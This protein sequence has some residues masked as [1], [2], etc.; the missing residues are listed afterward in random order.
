MSGKHLASSLMRQYLL[1]LYVAR[2]DQLETPLP[3]ARLHIHDGSQVEIA[4]KNVRAIQRF[5][6]RKTLSNI[7]Q[8]VWVK[9]NAVSGH[10]RVGKDGCSSRYG[11][12]RTRESDSSP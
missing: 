8:V 9:D 4:W 5:N 2:T 12:Q 3:I 11:L 6:E 10:V 1:A 7:D